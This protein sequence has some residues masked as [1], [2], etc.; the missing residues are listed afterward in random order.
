M[1]KN[2]QIMNKKK[3]EKCE[4]KKLID[5][6]NLQKFDQKRNGNCNRIFGNE[7]SNEEQNQGQKN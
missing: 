6:I 7:V 1:N 2:R 5:N 4:I 3:W